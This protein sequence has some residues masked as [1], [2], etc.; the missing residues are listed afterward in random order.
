MVV[1]KPLLARSL[2]VWLVGQTALTFQQIADCCGLHLLEI[3]AM[4]DQ[5]TDEVSPLDPIAAGFLTRE[6]I[7]RATQNENA[8]LH[9]RVHTVA[10]EIQK[11]TKKKQTRYTPLN[12]RQDRPDAIAWLLKNHPKMPEAI[13][14]RLLGTTSR[15]V[16]SIRENTYARSEAANPRN[17]VDLG[18]CTQ[19][20]LDEAIATGAV[21]GR[22]PSAKK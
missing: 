8:K 22:K 1:E 5:E 10:A 15:M 21:G 20:D 14:R 19:I 16:Q 17:P 18:M 11:R 7:E 9:I 13:I 4:A 12:K 2:A 6:D 3:Q